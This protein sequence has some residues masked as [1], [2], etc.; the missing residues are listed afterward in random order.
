[1]AA[2]SADG[3]DFL[4]RCRESALGRAPLLALA[5]MAVSTQALMVPGLLPEMAQALGVGVAQA[6][7]AGGVFALAAGLGAIPLARLTA[8]LDRRLLI[9]AALAALAVVN[10]ATACAASL[11]QMLVL[12]AV[13]GLLAALVLPAA[14]TAAVALAGPRAR[15][16]A[17]AWV[18]GGTTA[19]FG[20]GLPAASLLAEAFGWR[21][22]FVLAALLSAAVALV[23]GAALPRIGGTDAP[24]GSLPALLR[25]P[26]VGRTLALALLAFAAVFATQAFAGPVAA[27]VA[28]GG[29][30]G[31]QALMALGALAGVPLGR[32]LAERQPRR[33]PSLVLGAVLLAAGLQWWLLAMGLFSPLLQAAQVVLATGALFAASPVLQGRLVQAAPEARGLVLAANATAVFLGQAGGAA[34]GGLGLVMAE[35]AGAGLLGAAA[36][37]VLLAVAGALLAM[38]AASP[39]TA[40]PAPQKLAH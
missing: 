30:A 16:A 7:Q 33:A 9:V 25:L 18:T 26:G 23:L 29:V 34:L 17:L 24:G 1:M 19:A 2:L 8:R 39:A 6:G 32:R 27:Q 13:A 3:F 12:R 14:P 20:F 4:P 35:K 11:G 40:K 37:G 31:L 38:G 10:L 22:A 5:G 15:L 21:A 28:G 36:A